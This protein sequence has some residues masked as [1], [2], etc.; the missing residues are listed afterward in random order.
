MTIN[1]LPEPVGASMICVCVF[2]FSFTI[3]ET[4]FT[5]A[6]NLCSL[7]TKLEPIFSKAH[8]LT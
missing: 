7:K 1:D 5:V 8:S 2:C 6:S 4:I 3:L